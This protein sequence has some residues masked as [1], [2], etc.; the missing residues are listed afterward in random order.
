MEVKSF[1]PGLL[2]KDDQDDKKHHC[3]KTD[4]LKNGV[5]DED[6]VG[7]KAMGYRIEL[8]GQICTITKRYIV[9]AATPSL[10]I[11][12]CRGDIAEIKKGIGQMT[13]NKRED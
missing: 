9:L 3:I 13:D 7:N 1:S 12:D 8:P 5:I 4:A 11:Q 2:F 10:S 6:V